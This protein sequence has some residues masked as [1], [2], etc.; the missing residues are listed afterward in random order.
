M[1]FKLSGGKDFDIR[2]NIFIGVLLSIGVIY[3]VIIFLYAACQ[4][5]FKL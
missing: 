5:S 1:K 2:V 4:P 3:W